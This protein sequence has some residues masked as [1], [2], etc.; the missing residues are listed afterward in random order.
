MLRRTPA[1]ARDFLALLLLAAVGLNAAPAAEAAEARPPA[2]PLVACDPYFSVWSC[3]D[4]LTD[5]VTRHWTGRK[6]ALSSLIR[7]DGKAFRLMGARNRA[8]VPALPQVG[9]SVLPTRTI[10]EFEV[11]RGPRHADLPDPL[12]ARTTSTSSP[13]R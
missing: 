1:R 12:A 7:I 4:R 8:G 3:S 2:V 6:Q 11:A 5:D 10:Y 9:L 13:D